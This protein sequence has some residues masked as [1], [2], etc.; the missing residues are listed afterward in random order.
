METPQLLPISLNLQS[1]RCLVVGGGTV[2]ERRVGSLLVC[3]AAVQVISPEVTPWL[4]VL[5]QQGT[6]LWTQDPVRPVLLEEAFVVF[7]ATND[8]QTN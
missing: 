3:G 6:I 4:A 1:K 2:A 8:P 5:A 7:V